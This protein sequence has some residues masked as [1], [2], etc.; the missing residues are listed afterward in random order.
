MANSNRNPRPKQ[1]TP[2]PIEPANIVGGEEDEFAAPAPAATAPKRKAP[3]DRSPPV[4]GG[5]GKFCEEDH[6]EPAPTLEDQP[7]GAA[8]PRVTNKE[9]AEA[10]RI[11]SSVL[12][13]MAPIYASSWRG[14]S[15]TMN[16]A[17]VRG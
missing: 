3:I 5:K 2:A 9:L 10:T 15:R 1:V 16:H 13:C 7:T 12:V 14:S 17:G 8:K 6:L 11:S 4:V